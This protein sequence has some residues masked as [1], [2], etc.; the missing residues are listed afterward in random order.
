MTTKPT[1]CTLTVSADGSTCG[2]PAV[3][4]H[5]FKLS[6]G[7]YAECAEHETH[8]TSSPDL[9]R[10]GETVSIR[11]YGVIY[12]ALVIASTPAR[13]TVSF[14]TFEGTHKQAD[15]SLDEITRR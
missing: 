2:K 10:P 14:T 8:I 4:V 15:V 1:T 6:P 3:A 11:K 13:V 5:A 12:D 7:F 9:P